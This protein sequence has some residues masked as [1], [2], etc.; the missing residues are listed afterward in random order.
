MVECLSDGLSCTARASED[1]VE[2]CSQF[3]ENFSETHNRALRNARREDVENDV[4]DFFGTR[5]SDRRECR[6]P[7]VEV[8]R[9]CTSTE[10]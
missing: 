10:E 7:A 8:A 2:A 6:A 3:R 5:S 9:A 1:A 4:Q